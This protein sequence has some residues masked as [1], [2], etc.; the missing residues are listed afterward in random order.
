M[1][2]SSQI[3]ENFLEIISDIIS[4]NEGDDFKIILPTVASC[5]KLQQIIVEKSPNLA[6]ILPQIV[7][8]INV[9]IEGDDIYEVPNA[10]IEPISRLEQKLLLCNIIMEEDN[11]IRIAEALDLAKYVI[12]LFDELVESDLAIDS[13]TQKLLFDEEGILNDLA[14]HW[15][16][17]A[18]FLEKIYKRWKEIQSQKYRIDFASYKRNMMLMEIE[19]A[20]KEKYNLILGGIFPNSPLLIELADI[21]A[22]SD[23]S[24]LILPVIFAH[25]NKNRIGFRTHYSYQSSI[26]AEKYNITLAQKIPAYKEENIE[27][28]NAEN[29]RIESEQ[30]A[31][32]AKNWINADKHIQIAIICKNKD[33]ISLTE[34]MLDKYELGHVNLSGYDISKT[35]PYEFFI[36]LIESLEIEGKIDIERFIILLKSKFLFS[37]ENRE[38]EYALRKNGELLD[39]ELIGQIQSL[40]PQLAPHI[41]LAQI[42]APEIWQSMEGRI[43]SD[44]LYELI[45]INLDFK[46]DLNEYIDFIKTISLNVRYHKN[47]T[48]QNIFF[49]NLEDANLCGYNYIICSDMNEDSIPGNISL[50]PW[51]SPKMR[52]NVGLSDMSE[53]IGI[54]WY[55]FRNLL[56]RK[57]LYI[58]RS[59]KKHG[60]QTQPSR[61]LYGDE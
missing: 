5:I 50:D 55:H 10:H 3:N 49:T 23:N 28:F 48:K 52:E 43:F 35:K 4:K 58:T 37:E 6:A 24:Y 30:I 54:D 53:R 19:S 33:I 18:G 11:S 38:F 51:M 61:F 40:K 47:I 56:Y 9:G 59:L 42:L 32:K 2:I 36:S 1:I 31:I 57:Q 12:R 21:I 29:I 25:N 26:A 45:Q 27:Y 46:M 17:R 39:N 22:K 20:R 60:T 15:Q 44:F 13:L 8:V 41:E 14:D 34:N 7:P 16:I